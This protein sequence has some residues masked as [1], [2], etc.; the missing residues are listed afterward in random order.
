MVQTPVT[1]LMTYTLRPSLKDCQIVSKSLHHK[2][3]NLGD[4]SS[5]VYLK[6]SYFKSNGYFSTLQGAWIWFIYTRCQNIN[7]KTTDDNDDTQPR[8]KRKVDT[9]KHKYPATPDN[10]EDEVSDRSNLK[11]LEEEW[12][13]NKARSSKM[14]TLFIRTH[15]QR[16]ADIL[17]MKDSTTLSLFLKYPML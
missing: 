13:K 15:K 7:Q 8:K 11:L 10:A 5:K 12:I 17:S 16:R 4:E 9:F 6:Q 3:S 1:L 2:F 14:K